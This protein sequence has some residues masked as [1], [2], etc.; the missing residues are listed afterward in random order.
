VLS[1]YEFTEHS[2]LRPDCESQRAFYARHNSKLHFSFILFLLAGK[3]LGNTTAFSQII[4]WMPVLA[5]LPVYLNVSTPT[6][7]FTSSSPI[8][9]PSC[10][11][12]TGHI[13]PYW[14]HLSTKTKM[15]SMSTHKR[16]VNESTHRS[17]AR[18]GHRNVPGRIKLAQLLHLPTSE[19][20]CLIAN[21]NKVDS[22]QESLQPYDPNH[23]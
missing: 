6:S 3:S 7:S 1:Y 12:H 4:T 16:R 19:F 22:R 20:S 17:V 13:N 8:T 14:T 23:C 2:I 9:Y 11:T 21:A 5:L 10:P 15:D 18:L